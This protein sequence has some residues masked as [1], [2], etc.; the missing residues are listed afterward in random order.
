PA[1][2]T[3][4]EMRREGWQVAELDAECRSV[5]LDDG[6]FLVARVVEHHG[7]RACGAMCG[8]CDQQL[9]HRFRIDRGLVH[10]RND[11][12]REGIHRTEHIEA[13][14]TRWRGNEVAYKAPHHA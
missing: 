2:L 6:A 9:A 12:F 1:A 10:D 5:V 8:Q 13:L 3:Q 11:L 14:A 4:V 7:D